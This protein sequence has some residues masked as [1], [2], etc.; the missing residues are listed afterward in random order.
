MSN[1]Y[2]ILHS[3]THK[4]CCGICMDGWNARPMYDNVQ[5]KAVEVKRVWVRRIV[6][7]LGLFEANTSHPVH[8]K[9]GYG[10]DEIYEE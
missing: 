8:V 3:T 2:C 6:N 9:G 10:K 1:D 4:W 5:M 7:L